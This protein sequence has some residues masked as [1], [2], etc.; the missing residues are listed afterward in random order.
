[1]FD[2][3]C[4]FVIPLLVLV[5]LVWKLYKSGIFDNIEVRVSDNP[6][7]VNKPLIVYYKHHI[8]AYKNV[9][10]F[11]ESAKQLM[12]A[13]VN[14]FGIYYDNPNVENL[15]QSVTGVVFG[16]DGKD[17]YDESYAEKLKMAGYEKLVLPAVEAA[18]VATQKNDGF[19]SFVALAKFTYSKINLFI[20]VRC[21]LRLPS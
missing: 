13:D 3:I 11:M 2:C 1:M 6:P 4:V 21:P 7:F 17:L 19:F 18:V 8:G 16:V 12:P 5:Y 10:K 9:G 14:V 15:L 20:Q